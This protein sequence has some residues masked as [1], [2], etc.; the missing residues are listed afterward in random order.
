M[1][2]TVEESGT[3]NGNVMIEL[4]N[5]T[6]FYGDT[7]AVDGVSLAVKAGEIF[8]FIGPN[9]AGKT[10]T[11]RMMGGVLAPTSGDILIGGIDMAKDPQAAK[12]M[13][14]FIPD[15]P[16]LYE[17][18]T[19]TEFL[20]FSADLYGVGEEAFLERSQRLLRQ[21]SLDEWGNELVEAYSH[22]MKQRL[23]IV[24]ALLHEPRV[25]IVDE[26]MV[27]LDPAG[28]K[29][30]KDILRRLALGGTTIFMSTHTLAV[31]E[32][33]C[34][35]IGV[36]SRGSVIAAGT[37]GELKAVAETQEADLEAVFLRLTRE[38]A[39]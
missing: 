5:L 3:M 33:L 15:R 27:G 32:D 24:A 20:R 11:I 39:R 12:Q 8:G 13:I 23:I 19:G 16:F 10:T 2:A 25:I 18:L 26:P 6:K 9:G 35:R 7:K 38:E 4:R 17:K 28:I 14:G 29:M 21:F 36:I 1:K 22:G 37:V 34:D 31:A 30:V